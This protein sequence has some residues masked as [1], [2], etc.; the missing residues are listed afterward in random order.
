MNPLVFRE[1]DIRG[2][3]DKDLTDD[4]MVLVGKAV[5]T[6]TRRNGINRKVGI[7]YDM[8]ISS[9]RFRKHLAK[10]VMSAG[11]DVVD[12]G[13]I[14]TPVL[15]FATHHL[16]LG[17]A[18]EI[19]GSHNPP[20]Y[21]GLKLSQGTISLSGDEIRG[22]RTMIEAEDFEKGEGF[23][24]KFDILTPYKKMLLKKI[25]FDR[26]VHFAID[27][28]N[29]MAGLVAPE[30]F[31]KLNAFPIELYCEPDGTFPNHH[32]DPT[33]PAF[34]E[35][36]VEVVR[37]ENLEFGIA[38]DGDGDRIG[39]V[40][41]KGNM[42][43]GDQLLILFARDVLARNPGA[44]IIFDVKCSNTLINDI[45]KN[46][47]RP[48]MWR[49]GHSLIKSKMREIHAP[50]AGEMSGHMFFADD[51]YGFDDALYAALRL[52]QIISRSNKTISEHLS[53]VPKYQTTPE[54][55][56]DCPDEIKFETIEKLRKVLRADPGAFDLIEVD[57]VRVQFDD[58]W[59]LVRASNTQA[60]LVVRFEAE[61]AERLA[62]VR[63]F[64]GERLEKV[65][66]LKIPA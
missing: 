26:E 53:D 43:M 23:M 3:V 47:G 37:R 44:E 15:Y 65:S 38:F 14:P 56:V 45:R 64:I 1:Y 61:T 5:G 27:A 19:T 22:I 29:G 54:I 40:D 28:G 34:L 33:V 42:V 66:G 2:I 20:E 17:G 63:E 41:E 31:N 25:S 49:S 55:R 13:M 52:V 50:L 9:S 39:I 24:E 58:A 48:V 60:I 4:F 57:G 59:G 12:L 6:L 16:S 51:F 30:I 11:C 10:G 62:E 8:R 36:L 32:P 21:N 18:I 35:D 7:G 46:G